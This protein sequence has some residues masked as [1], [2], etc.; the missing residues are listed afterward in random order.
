[1]EGASGK[2]SGD[3]YGKKKK[4]TFEYEQPFE[5]NQKDKKPDK[6]GQ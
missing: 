2:T 5:I 4:E 1:L 6:N 3:G